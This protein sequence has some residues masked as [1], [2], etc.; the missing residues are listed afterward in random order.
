MPS[1]FI[2]ESASENWLKNWLK[3]RAPLILL[4]VWWFLSNRVDGLTLVRHTT[5]MLS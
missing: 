5:K 1:I 3:R 4:V 2:D